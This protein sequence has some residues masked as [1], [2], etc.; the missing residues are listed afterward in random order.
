MK[1]ALPL[2]PL[3]LV[4]CS[5][6]HEVT[7]TE[8]WATER[9]MKTPESVLYDDER[10]VLYV[11]NINGSPVGKD[12]NG[13]ISKL[14]IGGEILDLEWVTGLNA[15]KGA[16]RVDDTLYVT[17][18]DELVAIDIS[19]GNIIDRYPAPGAIFLNDVAVDGAG[20]V[21]ISD[22]S[23]E[24]GVIYRLDGDEVVRWL[25]DELI[26]APNGLSRDGDRLLVGNSGDGWIKAV[27]LAT[28]AI[29][30]VA[31]VGSGIDGLRR[32]GDRAYVVSDWKGKTTLVREDAENIVIIQTTDDKI[33]AADLEFVAVDRMVVIPT[34]YDDRVVAYT[35]DAR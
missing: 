23:E 19:S 27:D 32:F 16:G 2:L 15:P 10:G 24:N 6:A 31:E 30:R 9:I 18:I 28:A 4:F 29:T 7:V 13:F 34:F 20:T 35:V 5:R 14:S 33:N 26:S 3:V 21:Y 11:S 8:R 17:D 12:G 22:S 25:E 1:R